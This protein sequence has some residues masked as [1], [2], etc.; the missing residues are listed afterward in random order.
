MRKQNKRNVKKNRKKLNARAKS[1][2][3]KSS[4]KVNKTSNRFEYADGNGY[5]F[6][7]FDGEKEFDSHMDDL[8]KNIKA[9][10]DQTLKAMNS[11]NID[12]STVC[13]NILDTTYKNITTNRK[14]RL[15]MFDDQKTVDVFNKRFN[16]SADVILQ[17]W[18]VKAYKSVILM[19]NIREDA[20]MDWKQDRLPLSK[21]EKVL[22]SWL[23]DTSHGLTGHPFYVVDNVVKAVAEKNSFDNVFRVLD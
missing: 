9:E 12:L 4:T 21:P 8:R 13:D 3:R 1:T 19:V 23:L 18:D 20:D 5:G 17:L 22:T 2:F 11:T 16:K 7:I 6:K 14:V 15:T 10:W